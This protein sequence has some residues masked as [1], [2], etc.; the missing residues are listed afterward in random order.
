MRTALRFGI[1]G[2]GSWS[3]HCHIPAAEA[4]DAVDFVGAIGR[5]DDFSAFLDSVDA[6]GFAVPPDTQAV[7]ALRAIESGKHVLLDKPVALDVASAEIIAAAAAHERVATLV[8]LTRRFMPPIAAWIDDLVS[9]GGWSYGRIE[10]LAAALADMPNPGWRAEQ[11][12]LW[13]VGPH[14]LSLLLPV[15]GRVRWVSAVRDEN[16]LVTTTLQH[17]AA[18]SVMATTLSAPAH[19]SG[20]SAMFSGSGGRSELPSLSGDD[21][22]ARH[23]YSRAIDA[24]V[25]QVGDPGHP[26]DAEFG[27]EIV[28]ILDAA[29]RSIASGAAVQL[30]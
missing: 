20:D 6:V 5:H 12:G 13:D 17:D 19:G 23:A 18:T 16:Q 11:G 8:F 4:H 2:T 27:A 9:T 26:C 29:E 30:R 14:A 1:V 28:R 21:G 7:L 25:A 15:L 3:R 24:L 10:I 22:V